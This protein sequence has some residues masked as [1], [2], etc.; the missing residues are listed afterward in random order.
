T[1]AQLNTPCGLTVDDE[2]NFY[3]ADTVNNRIRKVDTAGIITTVAGTGQ[4]GFSGDGGPAIEAQINNPKDAALDGN[5]NLYIADNFNRRVRR[6]SPSGV[7]TTVAGGGRGTQDGVPA[8]EVELGDPEGLAVDPAGNLYIAD[9]GSVWRVDRSGIITVIAGG[10]RALGDGGPATEADMVP[11][12]VVI[13][14]RGNLYIADVGTHRVRQV[15]PSSIIT[16]IAG[17]G[18]P[19]FGGDEGPA[20]LAQL[21]FPEG[22]GI[23]AAGNTY[24]ADTFNHRIRKV[25]LAP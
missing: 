12:D 4:A 17:T 8:T 23:D 3:I 10:G 13:D 22:V 24:I 1:Q 15:D 7:I 25:L 6:V 19:G 18:E 2:G 16:T 5:G 14:L 21:A 9:F 11:G 20:S